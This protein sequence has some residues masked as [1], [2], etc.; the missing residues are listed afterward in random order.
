MGLESIVVNNGIWEHFSMFG[1]HLVYL[2][3]EKKYHVLRKDFEFHKFGRTN[4]SI[5]FF[6]EIKIVSWIWYIW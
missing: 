5:F 1:N 2:A 6:D 3:I 4:K